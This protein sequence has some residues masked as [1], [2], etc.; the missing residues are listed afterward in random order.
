VSKTRLEKAIEEAGGKPK[1]PRK[2]HNQP[3][4][5]DGQKFDSK[6]EGERYKQLKLLAQAGEITSLT[7]QPRYALAINGTNCGFYQADFR[8]VDE[9]SGPVVVEDVKSPA[10]AANAVFRLKSKL[11]RALYGIEITEVAA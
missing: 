10:T 6:A 2:Y 3:V 7:L 4:V 9:R 11:V 1:R 8:Y 5:I